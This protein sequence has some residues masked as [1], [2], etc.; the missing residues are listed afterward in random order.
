[1]S[2]SLLQE[3]TDL[4]PLAKGLEVLAKDPEYVA[5]DRFVSPK[6]LGV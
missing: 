1:M 4:F 5:K 6:D 3:P 2:A